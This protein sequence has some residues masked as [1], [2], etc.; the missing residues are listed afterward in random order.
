MARFAIEPYPTLI[1]PQKLRVCDVKIS[2]VP[3]RFRGIRAI[4]LLAFTAFQKTVLVSVS[5]VG[6]LLIK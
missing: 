6:D 5:V 1:K 2:V 4:H 3:G